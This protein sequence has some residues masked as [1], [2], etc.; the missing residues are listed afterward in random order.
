[1][2]YIYKSKNKR[3]Y[4]LKLAI[5]LKLENLNLKMNKITRISKIY[6]YAIT[7]IIFK[8]YKNMQKNKNGSI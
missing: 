3:S 5:L 4:H 2:Y 7:Y 6:K 1:M 8:I